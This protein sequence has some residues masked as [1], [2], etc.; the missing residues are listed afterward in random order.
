MSTLRLAEWEARHSVPLSPVTAARLRTVFKAQVQPSLSQS[1]DEAL[2]DLT[3]AGV[4]GA[5]RWGADQVVVTPKVP[6]TN[7]LFLL[8][9]GSGRDPWD[10][11]DDAEL[12]RAPDLISSV[13]SLFV[14]LA[15]SAL[16]R[17]VLRGYR[18]VEDDLVTVRGR[19]DLAQQIRRRPGLLLPLAVRFTEHDEDVLENQLLLAAARVLG[20]LGGLDPNTAHGLHRI[21][22][23]LADVSRIEVRGAHVPQVSWNRLNAHYRPAVE[24]ARTV[25]AGYGVQV[26]LGSTTTLALT[27]DMATVFE[28][29]V[30]AALGREL[31]ALDGS[32]KLQ[33][34]WVLDVDGRV[35]LRPDLVWYRTSG[36]VRAVVD[37]KYKRERPAG[38]P[39]ADTYQ[40]LAYC[41]ALQL[42]D[43]H[44]VYAKGN[45]AI[46]SVQVLHGGPAIHAHALDLEATPTELIG[47]MSALATQIAGPDPS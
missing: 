7:V 40:L 5:A 22:G 37:A 4:V 28:D 8:A 35:T 25:L 20:R 11:V 46:R 15:S 1:A 21:G 31:T 10:A 3:A 36:P 32:V 27:L 47:Q 18:D 19:I 43:G 41:T 24:L 2:W 12:A 34:T 14:R 9:V 29:F 39:E 45:D 13:A 30:C 33:D 42:P 6:I 17:G 26:D 44:L 38:Y 23:M 16:G